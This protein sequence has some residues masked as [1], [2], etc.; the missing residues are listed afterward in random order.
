VNCTGLHVCS[1][2]GIRTNTRGCSESCY[3]D[4]VS[5]S[6]YPIHTLD[7]FARSRVQYPKFY[8]KRKTQRGIWLLF[9]WHWIANTSKIACLHVFQ[10]FFKKSNRI[11]A[12][13]VCVCL[14]LATHTDHPPW[15]KNHSV[16]GKHSWLWLRSL[17]A[18]RAW[19]FIGMCLLLAFSWY[20]WVSC[21]LRVF[22]GL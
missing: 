11:H 13:F 18:L 20:Y 9:H 1:T 19:S 16:A 17:I 8:L 3:I 7:F 22:S 10:I 4:C 12:V 15:N 21:L 5:L 14:I 6:T 2:L